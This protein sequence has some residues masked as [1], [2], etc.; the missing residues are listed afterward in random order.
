M[1]SKEAAPERIEELSRNDASL[2]ARITTRSLELRDRHVD[3]WKGKRGE[4]YLHLASGQTR[5]IFSNVLGAGLIDTYAAEIPL[6]ASSI[7]N[8]PT[9]LYFVAIDRR[10]SHDRR[11]AQ[12]DYD[13]EVFVVERFTDD[14]GGLASSPAAIGLGP[15]PDSHGTGYEFLDNSPLREIIAGH[16]NG[17]V[18]LLEYIKS[19]VTGEDVVDYEDWLASALEDRQRE[20]EIE[21]GSLEYNSRYDEHLHRA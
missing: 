14:S 20:T 4:P 5:L 19:K 7:D 11:Y 3:L 13:G 15:G 16:M 21:L 18:G 2:L 12:N 6:V 8:R 17:P 9:R 1:K 10:P